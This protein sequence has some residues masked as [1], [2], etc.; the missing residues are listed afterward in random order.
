V[1]IALPRVG[2]SDQPRREVQPHED[3]FSLAA[4][5]SALCR[6]EWRFLRVI[7]RNP[8]GARG[9]RKF[10]DLFLLIKLDGQWKIVNKGFHLH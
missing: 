2:E 1:P 9:V 3:Q 10:T 5:G 4:V 8:V 6:I 7:I